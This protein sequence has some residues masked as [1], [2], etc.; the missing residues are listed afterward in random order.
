MIDYDIAFE[1]YNARFEQ[2]HGDKPI[3]AYTKFG[4]HMV[5][6]LSREDFEGKLDIY[7][8]LHG[9]CKRMLDG[10]T[11]ISDAL[12]H[13]FDEAAAWVCVQAPDVYSMFRGEMGTT[14]EAAPTRRR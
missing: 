4:K 11:T 2:T 7:V 13:E 3:G 5:Q 1:K 6:R 8:R 12:V 9:A 14:N 10:G